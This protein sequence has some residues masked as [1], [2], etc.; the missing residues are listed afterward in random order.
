MVDRVV[1]IER[2]YFSD[3]FPR[4]HFVSIN[5]LADRNQTHDQTLLLSVHIRLI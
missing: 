5:F 1:V 3:L 2:Q 4:F